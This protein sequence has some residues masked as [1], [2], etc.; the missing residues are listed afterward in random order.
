MAEVPAGLSQEPQDRLIYSSSYSCTTLRPAHQGC[1][2]SLPH[3]QGLP[4]CIVRTQGHITARAGKAAQPRS[5]CRA[6]LVGLA[7][8]ELAGHISPSIA[9]AG[10]S[11]TICTLMPQA[12][13]AVGH[14]LNP[15]GSRY[16]GLVRHPQPRSPKELLPIVLALAV[17]GRLWRG[18]LVLCHCEY[19]AVVSQVN[20]LHAR[21]P[22]A[23]Q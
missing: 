13:G 22:Q 8:G 15:I 2:H 1:L 11:I 6:S 9:H 18:H 7:P 19:T 5:T 20:R 10:N 12:P 21:D 4:Q 23:S 16:H 3:Q 17:W 14:G